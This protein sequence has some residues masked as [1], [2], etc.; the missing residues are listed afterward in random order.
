VHVSLFDAAVASLANQASNWL[1][2]RHN[3]GLSGSLHPN[4]APYGETFTCADG[5]F[6]VVACG[7]DRQFAGLCAAA[8]LQQLASASEYAINSERV[9]HRFELKKQFD[10]FFRQFPASEIIRLLDKNQVPAAI[11]STVKEV[12]ESEKSAHLTG[13]QTIEDSETSAV[14][15]VAFKITKT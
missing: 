3:P 13:K 4:I 1:M 5:R 14:L 15:T 8:N 12:F 11:I 2:A 7:N 9:K 10:S 6:I